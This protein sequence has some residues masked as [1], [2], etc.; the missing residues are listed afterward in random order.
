MKHMRTPFL[1]FSVDAKNACS[2]I[3][4]DSHMLFFA[5]EEMSDN[6]IKFHID[7]IDKHLGK[8]TA[9]W[10]EVQLAIRDGKCTTQSSSS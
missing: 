6:N 9:A 8:L 4:G 10:A 5:L 3:I 1:N 7:Q 2:D